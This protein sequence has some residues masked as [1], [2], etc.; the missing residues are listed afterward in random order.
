MSSDISARREWSTPNHVATRR[1]EIAD[2][3]SILSPNETVGASTANSF[4]P[5]YFGDLLLDQVVARIT[6]SY[7]SDDLKRLYWMKVQDLDVLAYRHEVWRDLTDETLVGQLRGF[8]SDMK[9]VRQ[10]LEWCARSRNVHHRRRILLDAAQTF[11]G[12]VSRLENALDSSPITSRGLVSF[13]R[14]LREY[15][16][17]ETYVLRQRDIAA[18]LDGLSRVQYCLHVQ[19]NRIR[20]RRYDGEDDFGALIE[21]TFGRFRQD[22][23][24]NYLAKMPDSPDL[25]HIEA[26][27]VDRVA[28]LFP[29]E[30]ATLEHCAESHQGFYSG[31]VVKFIREIPFYLAYLDFIGP[32][33]GRGL[34]FSLPTFPNARERINATDTFDVALAATR[35]T[36][37][38]P[39]VTNDFW[40]DPTERILLVSGPNQGGKTTFA[41]ALGQIHHL[42]M[43][44][45]PVPGRQVSLRAFDELYTHFGREEDATFSTGKLEDDLVRI[46]AVLRTATDSS[47]IIM[48]EIFASTTAHDAAM[49]GERLVAKVLELGSMCV[50]VTFIDEL[51]RLDHR[52]VSMMS[53]VD[54]RDP[55]VRTFKV[56][57]RPADGKAYAMAI[58]SKYGLTYDALRQRVQR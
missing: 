9:S 45:C 8:E 48:N 36:S 47:I 41:R 53:T 14:S 21:D 57:R 56:L 2:G 17:S 13:R 38:Q 1:D 24:T 22:A 58:A 32:L 19:A 7:E 52:I 30:F 40:L 44:G 5:T 37:S 26:S 51:A 31:P 34:T 55:A 33:K 46:Q 12:S 6:T 43:I 18:T 15:I 49:L 4:E 23:V 11:D 29:T 28:L 10:R 42:A 3:P 16:N 50:I 54:P 27:I 35:A 20:I 39:I 25:N